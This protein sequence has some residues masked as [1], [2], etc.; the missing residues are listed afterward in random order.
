MT[1]NDQMNELSNGA[2]LTRGF[3]AEVDKKPVAET[4]LHAVDSLDVVGHEGQ[5]EKSPVAGAR[6]TLDRASPEEE[7]AVRS[8]LEAIADQ[9]RAEGSNPPGES[10][11][12]PVG[13]F[14]A[15]WLRRLH[16]RV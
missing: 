13:R 4:D 7:V 12:Q 1:A 2:V 3:T 14:L 8:V 5:E 16:E 15:G 10:G 6:R 9:P 11:L